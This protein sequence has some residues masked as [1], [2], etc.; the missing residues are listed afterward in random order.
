MDR[1]FSL[2]FQYQ[3]YLKRIGLTEET[4]HP[5]QKIQTK[6]AFFGAIGQILIVLRDDMYDCTEDEAV[7]V[8]E[9]MMNEVTQYFLLRTQN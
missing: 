9:A 3:L 6:Q 8:M 5:E 7:Q 2:E 4:M 1:K